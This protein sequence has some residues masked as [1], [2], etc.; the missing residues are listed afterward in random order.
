M[1]YNIHD[2][3][4]GLDKVNEGLENHSRKKAEELVDDISKKATA[5][6]GLWI[7]WLWPVFAVVLI[8]SAGFFYEKINFFI[9]NSFVAWLGF[10]PS[11][12]LVY[13]WYEHNFT[14]K[15]PFISGLLLMFAASF[16]LT[17]FRSN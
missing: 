5:G 10:I 16:I 1:S 3:N 9:E 4:K 11:Y 8:A 13:N 12:I 17:L 6:R 14:K 15:H 2:I 7:I